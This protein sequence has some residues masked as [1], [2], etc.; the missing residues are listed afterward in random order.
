MTRT[1]LLRAVH[2]TRA[3]SGTAPHPEAEAGIPS[4]ADYALVGGGFR[5]DWHG[6][7]SLAT[8]SFPSTDFSWKAR[9][10]DHSVSDPARIR[11]FAISLRRQLPVGR[12][13]ST[14]VRAE[15]G[16][17]PHPTAVATLPPG[18]ALTGGGAEVHYRGAGNLLWKLESSVTPAPS[19]SA[20]SKDHG[21]TDPATLTAYALGVRLD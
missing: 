17:V 3:D 8:A 11:S 20:A 1:K 6:A 7:G 15:S 4:S 2:V 5:V 13:S 19:F 10:K 12:L 9:S 18:Y 14:I 21:I 16:Q